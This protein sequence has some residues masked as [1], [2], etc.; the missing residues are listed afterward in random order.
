[1]AIHKYIIRFADS[2]INL[3]V[4]LFVLIVGSYCGYCLWDNQQVYVEA[5][6]V[7]DDMIKIKPEIVE[8]EEGAS[9]DE[10][11]AIN[12]DVCAWLTLDNTKIDYSVLQGEDNLEYINKDVYGEF[13][14]AGSIYL[15]SR[16]DREFKSSYSLL[17]GHYMAQRRMFGDLELYKDREFF[18]ENKTG[19]LI[20]PDR[21]YDLEIF[22]CMIV[23][24]YDDVIFSPDNWQ[25]DNSYVLSYAEQNAKNLHRDVLEA[26]KA[27][28]DTQILA[29]STCSYEYDDARTIVL[30]VMKP[31]E[32]IN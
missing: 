26:A 8:E 17:Y 23:D 7:Q 32:T 22:C 29:M 2:L 20:L 12:P 9:F 27:Q 15:D 16:C 30:A 1:M 3:I 31:H 10:L 6:N 28:G 14:L 25:Y 18:N 11:L 5:G 24:Q 19:V 4:I 21:I 13:A